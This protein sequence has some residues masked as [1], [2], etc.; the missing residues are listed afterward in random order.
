MSLRLASLVAQDKRKKLNREQCL[1]LLPEKDYSDGRTQ[2]CHKDECDINKIM[3][4]FAQTGTISHI[5]KF[6]GVY[7][8]FSDFDFAT[9]QARL[10][11]GLQVFESLPGEVRREFDQD[12][13]KF[14]DFVNHPDNQDDLLEKL[15]A[16]AR[17]GDQLPPQRVAQDADVMAALAAANEPA[18][19]VSETN[20]PASPEPET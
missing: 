18:S 4:R 5:N 15:P 10:D 12:P 19:P 11:A 16:L 17:P 7:A 1:A 6:Q 14:F 9:Q 13:Q 2:Q 20:P 8:D 3:A